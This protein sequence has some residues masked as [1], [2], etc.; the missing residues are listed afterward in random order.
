MSRIGLLPLFVPQGV[1]VKIEGNKV[2]VKGEK[3][4]LHRSFFT[5]ISVALKDGK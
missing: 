3:G 2:T 5:G 1:E 4:E